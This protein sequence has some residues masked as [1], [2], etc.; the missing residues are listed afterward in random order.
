MCIS[1]ANERPLKIVLEP[2]AHELELPPMAVFY[3]VVRSN[4]PGTVE[5][6]H[7][8]DALTVWGWHG[9]VMDVFDRDGRWVQDF[10]IP[11]PE[12]PPGTG[13]LPAGVKACV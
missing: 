10:P 7:N 11:A 3:V 9:A 12:F 2:W 5:V 6:A 8:P 4:E 13:D 1:N